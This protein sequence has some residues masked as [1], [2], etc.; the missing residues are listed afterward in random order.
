[1]TTRDDEDLG[2]EIREGS[3]FAASV[4]TVLGSLERW[5]EVRGGLDWVLSREPMSATFASRVI[6]NFWMTD[7]SPVLE[8]MVFYEV[9]VN[10][11]VVTYDFVTQPLV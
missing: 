2:Y 7:F 11:R 4:D 10:Q 6:A 1:M 3:E 9:S 8:V 5:D